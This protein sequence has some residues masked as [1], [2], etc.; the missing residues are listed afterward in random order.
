MIEVCEH[1]CCCFS[2]RCKAFKK[3]V[4]TYTEC[5]GYQFKIGK[6]GIMILINGIITSTCPIR[7]APDNIYN[8]KIA[9]TYIGQNRTAVFRGS[10]TTPYFKKANR[11]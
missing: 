9:Q 7:T 6:N 4:Q 2:F 1:S 11:N 8:E 3:D 5:K 10:L